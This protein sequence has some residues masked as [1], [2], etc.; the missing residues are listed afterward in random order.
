MIALLDTGSP[1]TLVS[2]E[3]L[4]QVLAKRKP[5]EQTPEEWKRDEEAPLALRN[6]RGGQLLVVKQ[7]K[8]TLARPGKATV[9]I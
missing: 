6:Y 3:F 9:Q 5:C 2:L 4:L 1:V 8:I 7:V